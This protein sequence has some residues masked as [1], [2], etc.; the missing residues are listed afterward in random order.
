MTYDIDGE[1]KLKMMLDAEEDFK[2]A[3]E[4][5]NVPKEMRGIVGAILASAHIKSPSISADAMK[6]LLTKLIEYDWIPLVASHAKK[7]VD[8]LAKWI[9]SIV[10]AP[11]VAS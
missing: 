4:E 3:C 9:I 8:I 10:A 7:R 1:T 11:D 2:K 5:S 6:S